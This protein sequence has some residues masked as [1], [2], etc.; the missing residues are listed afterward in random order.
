MD[1][2]L[3]DNEIKKALEC[4]VKNKGCDD[5]PLYAKESCFVVEGKAIL[6][7]LNR[8]KAEIERLN[9]ECANCPM[10]EAKRKKESC[11]IEQIK[12]WQKGYCELKQ[13]LK[14]TK[15]EAIKE[16]AERL[17]EKADKYGLKYWATIEDIDNLVKEMTNDFKE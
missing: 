12:D 1:K 11:L 17:K 10:L 7:L 4:C 14:T 9:G 8:Q 6:D 15:S 5:C 16:F 2:K 13:K 3:T